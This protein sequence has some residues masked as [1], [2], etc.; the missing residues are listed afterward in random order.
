[1]SFPEN[2]M[3]F[4]K[5]LLTL[6]GVVA[7]IT[8]AGSLDRV[9]LNQGLRQFSNEWPSRMFA[10]PTSRS[11]GT[12]VANVELMELVGSWPATVNAYWQGLWR[13][14]LDNLQRIQDRSPQL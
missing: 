12:H 8:T 10:D 2:L 11:Y 13:D 3:L 6:S 5:A 9:M 1:M 14:S 7:D 4:R